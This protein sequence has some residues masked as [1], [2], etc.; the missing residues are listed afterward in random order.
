MCNQCKQNQVKGYSYEIHKLPPCLV[1]NVNRTRAG[2]RKSTVP[3]TSLIS[4]E[5]SDFQLNFSDECY[6]GYHYKLLSAVVHQGVDCRSGHYYT[7]TLRDNGV[8]CH[9]DEDVER[10]TFE[11]AVADI[12]VNGVILFYELSPESSAIT[13]FTEK[14]DEEIPK[15]EEENVPLS[16]G[17][18]ADN[19]TTE[20]PQVKI[21]DNAEELEKTVDQDDESVEGPISLE[22]LSSLNVCQVYDKYFEASIPTNASFSID[23]NDWKNLRSRQKGTRLPLQWVNVFYKGLRQSNPFCTLMFKRHRVS[24]KGSRK[25]SG[26]I[27]SAYA[28]CSRR[29]TCSVSARLSMASNLK[30]M[31]FYTGCVKHETDETSQR[32][33]RADERKTLQNEL[34]KSHCPSRL[35]TERLGKLDEH[36]LASGNL[37][38]VCV[39]GSVFKQISYEGRRQLQSDKDLLTSLLLKKQDSLNNYIRQISASPSYVVSFTD[40]G[41]RLFHELAKTV[42]LHWDATGSVTWK[43]GNKEY[44]YYAIVFPNPTRQEEGEKSSPCPIA[45]LI[46]TNQSEPTISNWLQLFRYREKSIYGFRNLTTPCLISSDRSLPLLVSSLKVFSGETMKQY[47]ERSWRI[48]SGVA[49]D[50][51]LN[52][53]VV[54]SGLCHFMKDGKEYCRKYYKKE[55]SWFGMCLFRLLAEVRVL[56]DFRKLMYSICIVLRAELYSPI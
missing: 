18:T 12:A 28:Y 21:P 55:N 50:E 33:V 23:E 6:A 34:W 19:G 26:D 47:L 43:D 39:D 56:Q 1:L 17:K 29:P 31:V 16:E 9:N 38:G 53:M 8:V 46:S 30:C 7:Y 27:F 22:T 35:H 5:N 32:P 51:D 10:S 14:D 44:L 52:G 20:K 11:E 15:L 4:L 24:K 36:T 2:G 13:W 48:V 25:I 49:S 45:E 40:A 37:T 54:H 41:V 3:V 42:P